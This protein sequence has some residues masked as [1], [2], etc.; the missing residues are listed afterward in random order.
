[1]QIELVTIGNLKL[2]MDLKLDFGLIFYVVP[3]P[4]SI[5]FELVVNK[6]EFVVEAWDLSLKEGS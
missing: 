1:M 4:Y 3:L 2:E 5:L 6:Q